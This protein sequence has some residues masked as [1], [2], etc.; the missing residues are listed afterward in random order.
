MPDFLRPVQ[1]TTLHNALRCIDFASILV[2][3]QRNASIDSD[4]ILVFLCIAFLHQIV[5][6]IE[7][8]FREINATQD[9]A[10]YCEPAFTTHISPVLLLG[11]TFRLPVARSFLREVTLGKRTG[12]S[13]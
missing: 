3:T 11:R 2:E 8:A 6:N 9:L 5:K 1:N 4:P 12:S 13:I 10:S 7:F